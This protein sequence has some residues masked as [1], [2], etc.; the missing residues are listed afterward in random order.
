MPWLVKDYADGWIVF[1]HGDEAL[2]EVEEMGEALV[3]FEPE[4]SPRDPE[5]ASPSPYKRRA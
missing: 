1:R 2:R 3:R 5:P 4:P